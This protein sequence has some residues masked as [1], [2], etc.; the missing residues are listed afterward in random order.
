MSEEP[1]RQQA[2]PS[3]G[4]AAGARDETQHEP[5]PDTKRV[6]VKIYGEVYVLRAPVDETDYVEAVARVVDARMRELARHYPAVAQPRLAV[7]TAL[8]LADE[9]ERLKRYHRRQ[10]QLLQQQL[11]AGAPQ[12][13]R[14]ALADE[15]A[16]PGG[17][18]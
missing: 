18:G 16:A 13:Q 3:D 9:L 8:N 6:E 15:G 7:L 2:G 10:L 5:R 14:L 1:A 17:D 4:Q 11:Q 12:Q